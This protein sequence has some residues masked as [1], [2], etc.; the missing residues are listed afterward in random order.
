MREA[1]VHGVDASLPAPHGDPQALL[2]VVDR[3]VQVA[4]QQVPGAQRH[5]AEGDVGAGQL[6]GHG[7]DR[8]VAARGD[9]EPGA[10]VEG[11][12]CHGGAGVVLLRLEHE[13]LAEALRRREPL[14]LAPHPVRVRLDGV[15]HQ[16]D[17][18]AA[19]ADAGHLLQ[20]A[21][22]AAHPRVEGVHQETRP[23]VLHAEADLA[24]RQHHHDDGQHGQEH[25][26][27]QRHPPLGSHALSLGV[28][29]AR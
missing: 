5:H 3:Q 18:V 23:L 9:H 19:R 8:A 1:D 28:G 26:G 15:Q 17:L 11:L 27:G 22:H 29:P 13:H 20:P 4:G 2:D 24:H 10:G 12:P 25:Q 14:E 7:A 6:L 21:L 16:R